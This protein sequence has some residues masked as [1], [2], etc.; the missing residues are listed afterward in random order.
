MSLA[1]RMAERNWKIGRSNLGQHFLWRRWLSAVSPEAF[2]SQ[3]L[4]ERGEDPFDFDHFRCEL[5]AAE[6]R[7]ETKVAGCHITESARF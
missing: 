2:S 6:R 1:G 7:E 4:N 3:L 5:S